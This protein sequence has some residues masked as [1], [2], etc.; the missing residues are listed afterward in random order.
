MTRDELNALLT[1]ALAR[2]EQ[3]F[4]CW[5]CQ[6]WFTN[7]NPPGRGRPR[8]VCE[9]RVCIEARRRYVGLGLL[10]GELLPVSHRSRENSLLTRC[11]LRALEADWLTDVEIAEEFGCHAHFV[12]ELRNRIGKRAVPNKRSA[13]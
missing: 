12:S 8:I 10:P 2:G 4:R 5:A 6:E 13:A 11:V 7:T 9:S 3:P 1:L